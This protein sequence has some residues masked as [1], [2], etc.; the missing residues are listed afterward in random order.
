M[1]C[2]T[3]NMKKG[4]RGS[5]E[6]EI[7]EP[8][9]QQAP[10]PGQRKTEQPGYFG[11]QYDN[12]D[13]GDQIGPEPLPPVALP[14]LFL[15]NLER[16]LRQSPPAL[17]PAQY[18]EGGQPPSPPQ[19]EYQPIADYQPVRDGFAAAASGDIWGV[20]EATVGA[21]LKLVDSPNP[22]LRLFLGKMALP[23][24]KQ[25]YTDKLTT[26]DAWDEV[27]VAAHGK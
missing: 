25:A 17:K 27:A 24:A 16:Q 26:W 5:V 11:W 19:A 6:I 8:K 13:Q 12:D 1:L 23:W 18:P 22:P 7:V 15:P 3:C 2:L 4:R 10:L 21:I 9:E 14:R 20:P